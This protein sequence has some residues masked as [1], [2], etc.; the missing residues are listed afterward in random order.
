MP[1]V[2]ELNEDFFPD[3]NDH[4]QHGGHAVDLFR[5]TSYIRGVNR[6]TLFEV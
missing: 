2:E 6:M 3:A 5:V 4:L 1:R